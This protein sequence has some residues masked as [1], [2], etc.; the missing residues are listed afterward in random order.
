MSIYSPCLSLLFYRLLRARH[1]ASVLNFALEEQLAHVRVSFRLHWDSTGETIMLDARSTSASKPHHIMVHHFVT[2]PCAINEGSCL[3]ER[4]ESVV[5][6]LLAT[7]KHLAQFR[8]SS[9]LGLRLVDKTLVLSLSQQSSAPRNIGT[10]HTQCHL[11]ST[12][13]ALII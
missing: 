8:V 2:T 7:C 5:S 4:L 13:V 11:H 6:A 3:H 12:H 9:A 1:T 10:R